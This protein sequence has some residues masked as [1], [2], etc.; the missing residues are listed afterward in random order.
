MRIFVPL[1][2][3]KSA[4]LFPQP[5]LGAIYVLEFRKPLKFPKPATEGAA[6]RPLSSL[7]PPGLWKRWFL[8]LVGILAQT[9]EMT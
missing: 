8:W 2:M 7:E 5:N 1:R 9:D 4:Q 3:E 6:V